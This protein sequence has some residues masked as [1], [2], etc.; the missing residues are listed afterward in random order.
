MTKLDWEKLKLIF[1]HEY[2]KTGLS[3]QDWCNQYQLNYNTA[4]R[5]IKVRG[6]KQ[7]TKSQFTP[8]KT[9]RS[10]II[11][12]RRGP[13]L[14]SKNALKHGGY[15]ECFYDSS[16]V[17]TQAISKKDILMLCR[18]RIHLVIA[19]ILRITYELERTTAIDMIVKLND[20][21]LLAD[22]AIDRNIATIEF[23]TRQTSSQ[24]LK[25]SK[26]RIN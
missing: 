10:R 16:G 22:L 20:S 13:P 14:G 4:R 6:V 7:S 12:K 26:N 9:G 17:I 24:R 11:P 2:H 3:A 21:L 19:E 18:N 5:Y 23:I 1:W 15:S 8:K 25:T